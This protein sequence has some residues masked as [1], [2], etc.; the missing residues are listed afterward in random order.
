MRENIVTINRAPVLTLW[1]AVVAEHQ[2]FNR[3]A[4]LTLGKAVSGL[5]AQAKG[6]RL[7]LFNPTAT[8]RGQKPRK[9]G[10]GEEFWVR[11]CGRS[12]PAK[13]TEDGIRAVV[14]DQPLDPDKVQQYLEKSFGE[15][16]LVV[17]QAMDDLAASMAPEELEE[18]SYELYEKFRP[19]IEPGRRGWGQKGPLD[20]ARIRSLATPAALP[21]APEPSPPHQ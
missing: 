12:V 5:N 19:P 17:R 4:A 10:L 14:K 16:L 21:R 1:A 15:A 18:V 3:P 13:S 11:V 2:G 6:R 20:L 8:E 7:G 9:A